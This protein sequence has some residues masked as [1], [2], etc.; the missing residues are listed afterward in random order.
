MTSARWSCIRIFQ[1]RMQEHLAFVI[2]HTGCQQ[3]YSSSMKPDEYVSCQ[4]ADAIDRKELCRPPSGWRIRWLVGGNSGPPRTNYPG[5]QRWSVCGVLS[6]RCRHDHLSKQ[7]DILLW[8]SS[9][10]GSDRFL[11]RSKNPVGWYFWC[12]PKECLNRTNFRL[13]NSTVGGYTN[14]ISIV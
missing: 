6:T 2:Y 7:L 8:M 13:E 1:I 5:C 4:I 10:W 14:L 9:S 12:Q 3:Q 11:R